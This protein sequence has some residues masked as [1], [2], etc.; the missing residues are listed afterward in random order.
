ML[1]FRKHSHIINTGNIGIGKRHKMNIL[2]FS[3]VAR[4]HRN[5]RESGL[6]ITKKK[7][8]TPQSDHNHLL[9]FIMAYLVTSVER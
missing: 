8:K 2:G 5:Q 3:D 9:V 4:N 6:Q 7:K 1:V